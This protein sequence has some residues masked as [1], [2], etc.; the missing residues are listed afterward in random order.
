M[1]SRFYFLFFCWIVVI[2]DIVSPS[3]YIVGSIDIF[4]YPN[5]FL[6]MAQY[7]FNSEMKVMNFIGLTI[8]G[9]VSLLFLSIITIGFMMRSFRVYSVWI[10]FMMRRSEV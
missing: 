8:L 10:G 5:T 9:Y 1:K 4:G 2:L 3:Y 6:G 7:S